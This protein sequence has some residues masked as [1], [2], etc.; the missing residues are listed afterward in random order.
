MSYNEDYKDLLSRNEKIPYDDTPISRDPEPRKTNFS[1]KKSGSERQTGKSFK[2]LVGVVTL[3][4]C[5]NIVLLGVL[6]HHIKTG[7]NRYINYWNNSVNVSGENISTHAVQKARYSSVCIAAGGNVYDYNSFY[8][9]SE[10]MGSGVILEKNNDDNYVY[11][12]TCYHVVDGYLNKINVQFQ[13]YLQPIKAS[14]VGYSSNYD[15]AVLKVTDLRNIDACGQVDASDSQKLAIGE[16]AF[17][18]GNSLSGGFSVTGGLISRINKEISVEGRICR[19][20]QIDAAINPG[21][22]GG[23]LFNAKG[24]F[25]GLVNSKLFTTKSGPNTIVAEGTAYAIPG[26]LAL[27]V[28]RS[29]IEN[30]GDA[31]SINLGVSF[32]HDE[33]Y[34]VSSV[35][36]NDK[37]IDN[38]KVIVQSVASG[39]IASGKLKRGDEIVSFTYIDLDGNEQTVDMLNKYCYEDVSFN[40]KRNSVMKFNIIR[41]IGQPDGPVEI[42]ATSISIQK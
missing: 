40:I 5:L 28:A 8:S 25:I 20:L 15:I 41:A 42:V 32:A 22:S 27:G 18:V 1:F 21:N 16:T 17:A 39:S 24:E 14:V 23:G 38:Y 33:N 30:D 3:M 36:V 37:L 35:M 7:G 13:G 26:T 29:I 34:P 12:L 10:N 19:E 11:I 9:N 2:V 6:I 31:T 4:F